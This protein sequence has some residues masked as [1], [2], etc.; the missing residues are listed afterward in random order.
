MATTSSEEKAKK[1]YALGADH[2]IN[3]KTTPEW[4]VAAKAK[5]PG[6]VGFDNII[7]VGGTGT[8]EESYKAIKLEGMGPR[9]GNTR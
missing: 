8:L 3:Y 9:R 4:G 5:T 1:L 7:E 6:G 2:V